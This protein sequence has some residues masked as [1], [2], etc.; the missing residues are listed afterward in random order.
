ML[1]GGVDLVVRVPGQ[2]D[3]AVLAD[4]PGAAVHQDGGVE[5]AAFRRQFG[6]AQVEADAQFAR[7]VEQRLHVGVGHGLLEKALHRF[8][9][10]HPVAR[11]ER[12]Q[13]QLGKHHELRLAGRGFAHHLDQAAHDR[14]AGVGKVDGAHLGDGQAHLAGGGCVTHYETPGVLVATD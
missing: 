5:L 11:K 10:F 13:R 6:I 4:D 3:L 7:R 14:R 2:V 9:V 8:R 12:R 1:E